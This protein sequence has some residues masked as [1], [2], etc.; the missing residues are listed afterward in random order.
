MAEV[1]PGQGLGDVRRRRTGD[2]IEVDER[3]AGH[4]HDRHD[5][6]EAG[7]SERRQQ[8]KIVLEHFGD[9]WDGVSTHEGHAKP[10]S[11]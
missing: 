1:E 7:V 9:C 2:S 3:L 4:Q 11:G 6:L 5:R 10:A 8:T